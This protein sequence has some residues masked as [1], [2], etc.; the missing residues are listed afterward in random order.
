MF[1]GLTKAVVKGHGN[2]KARS[3][4]VCIAQAANAVRGDMTAKIKEMIDGVDMDAI[5][6]QIQATAEHT[7]E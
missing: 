1:L 3:F 4:S 6:A 7:A 5:Q 2:S